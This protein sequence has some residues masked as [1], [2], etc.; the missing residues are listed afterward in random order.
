MGRSKKKN[1]SYGEAW[2]VYIPWQ[3]PLTNIEGFCAYYTTWRFGEFLSSDG[4]H[5][6][7]FY[8]TDHGFVSDAGLYYLNMVDKP[9]INPP[10]YTIPTAVTHQAA[11]FTEYLYLLNPDSFC[12]INS[13]VLKIYKEIFNKIKQKYEKIK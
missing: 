12:H 6:I 13:D 4:I 8:P 2:P 11:Q 10:I 9:K 1:N 7:P 5:E 3:R